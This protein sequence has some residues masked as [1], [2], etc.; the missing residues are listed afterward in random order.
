M[1]YD[2]GNTAPG[3][4]LRV[5][6]GYAWNEGAVRGGAE[7]LHRGESWEIGARAERQLSHTN[8]FTGTFEP[9]P[10]VPPLFG[11]EQYDYVDRRIGSLI[12]GTRPATAGWRCASRPDAPATATSA[13]T[14]FRSM[15]PRPHRSRSTH[16]D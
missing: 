15:T 1:T 3:M 8:D 16:H 5:H 10:G 9:E 7:V 12:A 6:G 13:A 11:A 2:F 14:W 4:L